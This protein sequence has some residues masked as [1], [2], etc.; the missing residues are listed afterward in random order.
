MKLRT[1]P[2]ILC[3]V[4]LVFLVSLLSETSTAGIER[5]AKRWY[6]ID[7]Y[8][9]T[10]MAHGEY[11]GLAGDP[12]LQD[13]NFVA[14]EDSLYEDAFHLGISYAVLRSNF[15]MGV[16][17]RFTDIKYKDTIYGG[18]VDVILF[19]SLNANMTQWDFDIYLHYYPVDLSKQ[20]ISPY[21][22]FGIQPGLTSITARG[23]KSTNV[24]T[25]ALSLD[26]G[27]DVKIFSGEG[28]RSF[29][30]LAS[31]NS[32]QFVGTNDRPKYLNVG[33]GL[34]YFFRP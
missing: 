20:S 15:L 14:Q 18:E 17:F 4:L 26:F 27:G 25:F 8:G 5:T 21:F 6:M 10:S 22:G 3:L 1:V 33:M 16:G 31:V 12:I 13:T 29:V 19:P 23:H 9:G 11:E 2:D 28:G 7:I 34:K 24:A 32:Y 30:T